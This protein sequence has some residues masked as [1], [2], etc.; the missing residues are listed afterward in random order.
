MI[1]RKPV[2]IVEDEPKQAEL[3]ANYVREAGNFDPIIAHNGVDAF[4]ILR[5][6]RR[7]LGFGRNRIQCILLDIR[8]P[9]M[10]GIEFLKQLRGQE[11]AIAFNRHIPVV[12][13][14]AYDDPIYT[15]KSTDPAHG[16]VAGYLV[17]PII[18]QELQDTLIRII[19][20][21]DTEFLVEKTFVKRYPKPGTPEL[22]RGKL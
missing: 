10:D 2:L 11:D 18:P 14:T 6:N 5:Q 7:W 8:M 19:E 9:T 17:K 1:Q 3:I 22:F 15:A 13:L 12:M 20:L 4:E 16:L 21:G